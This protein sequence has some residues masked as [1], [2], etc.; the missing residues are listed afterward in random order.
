[1][2]TT[3]DA[4][5][6]RS[7]GHSNLIAH[8]TGPL[9]AGAVESTL[10][11]VLEDGSAI[12]R[13]TGAT[14]QPLLLVALR[15][16]LGPEE[17][18]VTATLTQAAGEPAAVELRFA[19]FSESGAALPAMQP[20]VVA[21]TGLAE[22]VTLTIA[23]KRVPAGGAESAIA[24][25]DVAGMLE[26]R[27]IEGMLGRIAYLLSAETSR[28]RRQ[29][30]EVGAMRSLDTARDD[31][32]DRLGAELGVPRF[33][34][35][36]RAVDGII[37]TAADREAD[38]EYR[39]RL[40]IYRP[41]LL[42]A[43]SHLLDRL[44]GP[45]DAT[46]ANSGLL[47]ALGVEARV[48]LPEVDNPFAVAVHL[49]DGG[50]QPRR[51]NFLEFARRVHLIWPGAEGDEVHAARYLPD[52]T[53]SRQAEMRQ[54]LAAAFAWPGDAAI[55]PALAEALDRYARCRKALGVEAPLTVVRAQDAGA[56][57]RFELGLGIEIEAPD[58]G[59]LD[60]LAAAA[61][62]ANRPR[63]D[64]REAEALLAGDG[65]APEDAAADPVGAWLLSRC[66]LRTVHQLDGGTVY[67]SHLPTFGM[68]I[69][70]P[71]EAAVGAPTT[72]EVRYLAPG[73]R[74]GNVVLT[75][76]VESSLANLAEIGFEPL[77]LM[78]DDDAR[79]AWE[80]AAATDPSQS[81]LDI[82]TTADLPAV[83]ADH[84]AAVVAQ[85]AVIP[86][87]L[88]ATLRLPVALSD[89]IHAGDRDVATDL[90][91][92][93][94]IFRA[95]GLASMLPIVEGDQSVV[96][97]VG[98]LP[99][100]RAGVN[101]ADRRTTGFRWYAIPIE[102]EGGS[103][104]AVGSRTTYTHRGG[105]VA[106]VALGYARRGATDPYEFAVQLPADARLTLKQYEYLMNLLAHDAPIGVEINT[107]AI[108]QEHVDLDGDGV[109]DP[110]RPAVARTFRPFQRD[111]LRGETSVEV[112][113]GP[114]ERG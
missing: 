29:A 64:D 26:V 31:A 86:P 23:A 55:A 79:A 107:F 103:V 67:L 19:P 110:L 13:T 76:A 97:V 1:M 71:N 17:I 70:G 91:Q 48:A 52:D 111:R 74:G 35:D 38:D 105:L 93:A 104:K 89:R 27:M 24:A 7:A 94:G 99:L 5:R 14:R 16:D 100:P 65:T 57:S 15:R 81:A 28:L 113:D 69:T 73:D 114:I 41:F 4:D 59:V 36:L 47:A 51:A 21:E 30:R 78:S 62:D 96:V 61:V 101:L 49:V 102:G 39:R 43:R 109:A 92:L 108:R 42:P 75:A 9:G 40:A 88:I 50:P 68:T 112:P 87:E 32:L 80:S 37:T 56:G 77:E 106:L 6:W 85:L 95:Q 83:G 53:R 45:G 12:A 25:G 46:D 34:E 58:P 11:I 22:A 10:P 3:T 90:R 18:R 98:V 60:Q 66:G 20:A 63:S 82:L 2:S 84:L 54:R 33:S 72:F 44:N 8:L